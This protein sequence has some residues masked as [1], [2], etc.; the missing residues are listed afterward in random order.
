MGKKTPSSQPSITDPFSPTTNPARMEPPPP[1]ERSERSSSSSVRSVD[2]LDPDRVR[3]AEL[4]GDAEQSE[5]Q[6]SQQSRRNDIPAT[7]TR[8]TMEEPRP[9]DSTVKHQPVCTKKYDG[10]GCSAFWSGVGLL[11]F[12][13]WKQ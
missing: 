3:R 4:P 9:Y 8:P 1:Y 7:S 2:H 13:D 6:G 5:P 10:G 12:A 11:V